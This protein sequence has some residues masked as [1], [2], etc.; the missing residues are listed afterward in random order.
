MPELSLGDYLVFD[1]MGAYTLVAS[2]RFNGMSTP[3]VYYLNSDSTS[4]A[5]N[6]DYDPFF[7]TNQRSILS[8]GYS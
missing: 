2:S 1:N 5:M 3:K 7:F 4:P 8:E 6:P